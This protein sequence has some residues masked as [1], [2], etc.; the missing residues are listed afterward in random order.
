MSAWH[1]IE[2]MPRDIDGYAPFPVVVAWKFS[3]PGQTAFWQFC[4]DEMNTC[5]THW[6]RLSEPPEAL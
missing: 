5:A 1:L 6:M 4:T 3:L 2:T